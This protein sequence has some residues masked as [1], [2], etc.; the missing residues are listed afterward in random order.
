MDMT[1]FN[2]SDKIKNTTETNDKF[3]ILNEN[4]LN[5]F[6]QH[7]PIKIL[8]NKEAKNLLKPWISKGIL[9][10]IKIKNKYYSK[11]MKNLDPFWY[12]KYK[13]YRD[14]INHLIRISK[15]MYYKNY[16]KQFNTNIKKTWSGIRTLLS[17][18]KTAQTSINLQV[19]GEI[20]TD[21]KRVA[22]KF[23]EYFINIG[24]SLSN[25]ISETDIDFTEFLK[26]P[27]NTSMF[28]SPTDSQEINS[29]IQNLDES[30]S[31]DIYDTST[32]LL[33]VSS[34]LLSHAISDIIN[35]SFITGVFPDKLKCAYVL[36]LHKADSKITVGNYRPI[37]ILPII[38]KVFEKAVS[39]RLLR[40][41]KTNNTIFKH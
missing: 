20:I 2:F 24:P 28:F 5:I 14:K 33:K 17:N 22:N 8:S 18:K 9:G 37:S 13:V 40:F 35:H 41:L 1:N 30:K 15:I 19:D 32:M 34:V 25:Q 12:T 36:P 4:I 16:F 23:N 38:S 21:Q 10:S 3:N 26:N 11:Y 29:I 39:I 7:A 27:N 6:N 31:T